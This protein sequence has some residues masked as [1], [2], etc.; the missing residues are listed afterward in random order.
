LQ[1][2]HDH[3]GELQG[4]AVHRVLLLTFK[5]EA[6]GVTHSEPLIRESGWVSKPGLLQTWVGKA[7]HY[8]TRNGFRQADATVLR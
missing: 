3:L 8:S 1:K 6:S 7:N 4:V 5:D 2:L